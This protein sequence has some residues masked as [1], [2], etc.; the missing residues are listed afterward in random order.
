MIIA[1]PTGIKIFVRHMRHIR[2]VWTSHNN[3][4]N[5]IA[6]SGLGKG[7]IPELNIASLLKASVPVKWITLGRMQGVLPMIR[8]T[9][10]EV[11]F[12]MPSLNGE[13]HDHKGWLRT[14]PGMR[15][16]PGR[17][18]VSAWSLIKGIKEMSLQS[19]G[20]IWTNDATMGLPTERD[21]QGNGVWV[22]PA[23]TLG[24]TYRLGKPSQRGSHTVRPLSSIRNHC[25]GS[26][27]NVISKIDKLTKWCSSNP[28]HKVDRKLHKLLCDPKLLE[29][30]YHNIKSKPGNM[31]P[32]IT[33][34]TLDGISYHYLE[35]I[36]QSLEDESY[37]FKPGRR[38][39]IAKSDGSKSRPLTIAPP[40]DKIVQEAM[41]I[42]IS[43]V[44]E[45]T[46]SPSSHGFRPN[47]SCH[48]AL[49]DVRD[50]FKPCTWIIEGDI[51]KCFDT[52]DHNKLMNIVEYKILDRQ[53]TKL[54]WKSL[55]AGYFE[56][57][58]LNHNIIGTPQG[59]IISP[60]LSN[61]FLHQLDIFVD[62]LRVD[63]DKGN[64]ARNTKEYDHH[65]YLMKKAKKANDL[66]TLQETYKESRK[67]AVM[68]F[69]DPKYKRLKYVR[70]ADD[71][72][73]GVRGSLVETQEILSKVK[74]FCDEIGLTIN[75]EKT[76]ITNLNK[77]RVLFLGTNIFRS[78]VTNLGKNKHIRGPKQRLNKQLRLT[79]PLDR[80]RMKLTQVGF[81]KG[82]KPHP[83]FLWLPLSHKQILHLYNSVFRGYLNYYSFVH[84][85]GQMVG[86][87]NITLIRSLA[88]LLAAKFKLGTTA[89]V[90]RKFG[91]RLESDGASFLKPNYTADINRF[92]ISSKADIPTLYA[93]HLSMASLDNLNC[94]KCGSNYRVEMHHVK[95]MKDL[96]PKRSQIERMMI[97]A[98]RK[99]IALCRECHMKE[100]RTNKGTDGEPYDAK[101]S[102]T[103]RERG[104]E[105]TRCP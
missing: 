77:G 5:V 6:P 26:A 95:H 93:S 50:S 57:K 44:F 60:I 56:F 23:C 11:E 96:N 22:V 84:N 9:L 18:A 49:K 97:R 105:D 69:S 17:A 52:I 91:K 103:V 42:I 14:R 74:I 65:R 43:A 4:C 81:I 20:S 53:F 27:P 78:K 36:A 15:K 38:T 99:Q 34:E 88:K 71:W 67:Y 31:T 7:E 32:G 104:L 8:A 48:T 19:K 72:I 73:I 21:L 58:R 68:D 35:G 1:V 28:D 45:P 64:R 79:A 30:A 101:V 51:T 46:F 66:I 2:S 12:P 80:I 100:H 98:R 13:S 89:K 70:Y 37:T 24:Y 83:R 54:I 92:S 47:R 90:F 94:I 82:G 10:P 76:K 39:Y 3:C 55:K 59:S 16:W 33:P 87:V 63:F 41:R 85:Y 29:L 40:R 102:R 62:K 25:T 61:I 86:A 75:Q